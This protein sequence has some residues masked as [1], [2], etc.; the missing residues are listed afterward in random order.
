MNALPPLAALR[1]F[2]A[3]ARLGSVTRAAAELHVTHSAVSQ[4]ITQLEDA[5]GVALFLRVGRG[6]HLSEDGRLYA[7]QVRQGLAGLADAT[8]LVRA[9]P[10]QDELVIAVLPSFAQH[11]LIPRLP[12][13]RDR[14]PHYR[15]RLQASLAIQDLRQGLADVAIRMGQGNWDGLAQ[16]RL[17]DDELLMVAAPH[18]AG[19]QLPRTPAEIRACPTIRS[20]E[21]WQAWCD[22]AGL[23]IPDDVSGSLWVNDS[24]LSLEAVRLGQG[25]ALERRSLVDAALQRGELVALTDIRVPY[26][27]PYWLVWPQREAARAK[28]QAFTDWL[29]DEVARYQH[30]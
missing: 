2:E 27:Y 3:V 7:L 12:R 16:H 14:H 30:P 15:I 28:Q 1:S 17:F 6:L 11:W 5:L 9:R 20:N 8:R 22:A 25:V 4:Q 10:R 23:D 26:P 21:A 29:L 19:G 13:F 24:N 18:F